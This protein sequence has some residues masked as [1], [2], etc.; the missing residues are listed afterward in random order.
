MNGRSVAAFATA[1]LLLA[2]AA[3]FN[4]YPLVHYDTGTYVS[5]S[6]T[7]AV[8]LRRPVAYGIFLAATHGG[9]T[10]WTVVL[11]QAAIVTALLRRLFASSP[12]PDAALLAVTAALT[13][14]TSLP[15]FSGQIMPDALAG[16]C[17]LAL[18]LLL[19]RPAASRG[20]RL[21][22]GALVVLGA[23]VHHSH[24]PLVLAL[25]SS[26]QAAKLAFPRIELALKPAWIAALTATLAIPSL[27]FLL[28]GEFFYT[29]A[30]H[31]FVLGRM[32]G[33]GLVGDLLAERCDT[34]DYALCPYRDELHG[35]GQSFLW[36]RRSSFHRTGGWQAPPGPAWKMI[37][38]SIRHDPAGH[39]AAIARNTARQLAKF[40]A[41]ELPPYGPDAYVS[42]MVRARFPGDAASF[43]RARQ[44]AGTLPLALIMA[45]H[46]WVV[47][48]S[49]VA[50]AAVLLAA[51]R[52]VRP[53]ALDLHVFVWATLVF[54][55][56][57]MSNLSAVSGRY[58]GRLVW[59][60]PLAAFVT[61]AEWWLARARRSESTAPSALLQPSLPPGS[62]ARS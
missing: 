20:V 32:V 60:L 31:A 46:R 18:F 13:A 12:R 57:I 55:A 37:F 48:A 58:Q 52:G 4:G 27:N 8:P 40:D 47:W 9:I 51:L 25:V 44:Q 38:D 16:A 26:A 22:E 19:R 62:A 35:R 39:L 30:A 1:T 17:V 11:A 33:N 15:W 56:A 10:L 41:E 3:V 2:S 42:Q 14:L 7:F 59:L 61:A 5:S 36:D 6:F 43:A 21:F 49:A 28:T 34:D 50:S 24:L 54:N 23:A 29:K 53:P 45:I